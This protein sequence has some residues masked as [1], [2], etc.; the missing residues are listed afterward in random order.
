[1]V[2]DIKKFVVLALLAASV[3]LIVLGA[4]LGDNIWAVIGSVA[5]AILLVVLSGLTIVPPNYARVVT[6]FGQY[7]GSIQTSGFW[8][9]APLSKKESVSLQ[10]RNFKTKTLKVNDVEGNPN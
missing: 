9:V 10:V 4:G 2:K 3:H 1:L 6:F 7:I 5:S 8:F